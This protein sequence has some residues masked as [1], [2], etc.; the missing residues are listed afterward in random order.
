MSREWQLALGREDAYAV[1]RGLIL[2]PQEEGGL[3]QIGPGRDH[4][5][6]ALIEFVSIGNHRQRIALERRRREYVDLIEWQRAHGFVLARA[7]MAWRL[8][9]ARRPD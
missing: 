3:A 6:L 5:H 9:Y 8:R 2:R 7:R 1:I 4:L